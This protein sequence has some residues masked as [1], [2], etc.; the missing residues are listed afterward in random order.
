MFLDEAGQLRE[1]WIRKLTAC[2]RGVN[3][4]PK[5]VYYTLNPGGPSHG[6]F[7]RLFLDKRYEGDERPEDYSFIQSLVT[8]NAALMASQPDYVRQLQNLPPH[9][10]A[11]WL[12]GRWDVLEGQFFEDFRTE[13]DAAKCH[14]RGVSVEQAKRDGIWTHV[15]T[16]RE[17]PRE[18]KLYRSYDFGYGKPFSCA[19][20]GIDYDGT[21]YRIMELYG[22]TD[23]PNTGVKWSPDQ[24]FEEIA[25]I[26]RE[27]PWLRGRQIDGVA[28]PACWD[29]SRGESVAETAVRHGVYFTPGDHERIAGWMQ[30]HYRFQ[31]DDNGY[32]RI[33]VFDCCKAFIRTVPLLMYDA[34]HPE[35]LDTSMEDHCLT[36][37]TLVLTDKGYKQIRDMVGTE[38]MVMSHDGQLHRYSDVRMTRRN[39]EILAVEM[40]DGT[41]IYCTDDHRFMLPSGAWVRA[42][43][44]SAGEELECH[45]AGGCGVRVKSVRRAGTA[46]VYNMEVA[47]TH[48]FVIQGGVISHNC[49]DEARYMCMARPVSPQRP[50][51]QRVVFTD[52]LDQFGGRKWTR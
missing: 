32:A 6:Y 47:D 26:E 7:K 37:E 29:A 17:P 46:D 40:E 25:R 1:E 45:G 19:W 30:M 20:W 39:A 44:L 34:H 43:D 18:W 22:C 33:Y 28:D 11:M 12:E 3:G 52:P 4:F 8:D 23:E 24:Q 2:V 9:I 41:T 49:A 42:A 51:E 50:V 5:R 10:R 14:E 13:P 15:I 31:F 38:G 27:H 35:D 21:L 36:G 48:D 16:A